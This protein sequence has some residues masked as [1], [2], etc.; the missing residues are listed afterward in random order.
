MARNIKRGVKGRK[1]IPFGFGDYSRPDGVRERA[2]EYYLWVVQGK[3]PAALYG[4]RDEVFPKYRATFELERSQGQTDD[5]IK[6]HACQAL[7]DVIL[8][9]EIESLRALAHFQ[10][11]WT[12]SRPFYDAT[13]ELISWTHRFNLRGRRFDVCETEEPDSSKSA[14][15]NAIW[16]VV[17]A[18]ET[19]I[20]WHFAPAGWLRMNTNRPH[21]RVPMRVLKGPSKNLEILPTITLRAPVC[22]FPRAVP[23]DT[24]DVSEGIEQAAWDVEYE[25]EEQ[26]R[27]RIRYLFDLWLD[28][29]IEAKKATAHEGGLVAV[30]GKRELDHF[31]WTARYQIDKAPLSTIGRE[32]GRTSKAV[33]QA[34]ERV[35]DLIGLEKRPGKRGPP[36][37]QKPK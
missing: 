9:A 8:K 4:L 20:E 21:W 19:I 27:L 11:E 28:Q 32:V 6:R 23:L 30:P 33:E 37:R 18:L 10:A 25:A 3:T 12:V 15:R 29:Y 1:K 7:V 14:R 26:F 24:T 13:D 34:I 17:T 22:R 16:P 35:L 5:E 2:Q 36:R 31:Y